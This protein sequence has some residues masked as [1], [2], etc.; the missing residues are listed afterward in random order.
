MNSLEEQ[1]VGTTT[2]MTTMI[3]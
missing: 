3:L 2:T 1:L